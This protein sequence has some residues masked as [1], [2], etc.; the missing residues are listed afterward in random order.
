MAD[1]TTI[2]DH[3]IAYRRS[4]KGEPVLLVHGVASYSFLWQPIIDNLEEYY[5]IIAPDLLG[6]GESDKPSDVD[7]SIAAQAKIMIGVIDNL[8]IN[9]FHLV[10]H[11]IGGGIAQIM[12]VKYPDRLLDMTLI[13]SVGYDYWPIQLIKT[14]QVPILTQIAR[15]SINP[16]IF[17]Q[18][19]RH[20]VF[21]KKNLS[22]DILDKFWEPLKQPE[23]K[24]GFFNLIRSINNDLLMDIIDE[25][26]QITLPTL[27]I[28]GTADTYLDRAI[29]DNLKRDIPHARLEDIHEG[30]HFI[31]LD[32]ADRVSSLLKSFLSERT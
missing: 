25:I 3:Q 15:S 21:H 8:G 11:D 7:H 28:R 18:M 23:G 5:D 16:V 29:L 26:K 24:A 14:M 6:C 12:A 1:F 22:K 32:Q 10:G 31:Q 17:H 19:I 27:L 2:G 30:G 20:G 4:G 9:R 13:N